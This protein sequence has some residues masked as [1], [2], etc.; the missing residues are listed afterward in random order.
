MP[1][2]VRP[3]GAKIFYETKGKGVP[4]LLLAPD[5]MRSSLAKF[6]SHPYNPWDALPESKFRLI[7]MDQRFANRSTGTVSSSD[8]CH[9]F[10]SD[11]IALLDH[12][13]IQKCHILGSCIG[14]SFAF[15]LLKEHPSRFGRCVMLQP[16]GLTKH[17]TEPG[18][19]WEGLNQHASWMWFGSWANEMVETGKCKDMNVLKELHKKMFGTPR[20]F[21]FSISRAEATKIH[22]PLLILMG[23]DIFHPSETSREIAR[24]CTTSELVE[25]W[26]DVGDE[27]MATESAKIN[28]FLAADDLSS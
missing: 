25:K 10:M 3:S 14:P 28:C 17:T 16:I 26:R 15:Q 7:G 9:T 11:Q 21:V 12:L 24:I 13:E 5:G 4:V 27:H 8:G 22:H 2:L 19:P 20:D 1:H 18:T 6:E 23:R